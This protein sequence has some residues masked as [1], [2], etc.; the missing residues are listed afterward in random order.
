MQK[1]DLSITT[2]LSI[3]PVMPVVVIDCPEDGLSLA[4]ALAAGGLKTLE[5]TLRTPAALSAIRAI[6]DARPD[7]CIGAGTIISEDLA[8]QA[9]D[10]GADFA[11]SPGTTQA[12]VKRCSELS[13]P[14]LPGASTVTEIMSLHDVGF[15]AIKF[16]P[17][18]ASGGLGF[19]KSLASP[20]PQITICPT[21]GISATTAPEWLALPN[22]KCV[23]GS[24]VTPQNLI[25]SGDFATIEILARNAFALRM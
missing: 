21:G 13:L 9:K 7:I 12:I 15:Q 17:A 1:N 10:A 25:N 20:L 6:A 16:F 2:I 14:L 19:I 18:V 11:V 23:G 4:D 5:I 3:G 24:W 8:V 22:V